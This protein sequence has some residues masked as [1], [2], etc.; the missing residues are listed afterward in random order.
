[1]NPDVKI[2]LDIAQ[3]VMLGGL[4]WGLA[5]MSKA[6]DTLGKVTDK[7]TLGLERIDTGL[8]DMVSRVSYLEGAGGRRAGD[9]PR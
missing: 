7:L 1:M 3:L 8:T 5:R 6:V 9:R 2:T 4:I